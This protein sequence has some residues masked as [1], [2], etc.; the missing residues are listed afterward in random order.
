M[1]K[2]VRLL[3]IISAMFFLSKLYAQ[4]AHELLIPAPTTTVTYLSD[5]I[6]GDTTSSGTRK[7]PDRVYLLQ[8][9]GVYYNYALIRNTGWTLRIKAQ[10]GKGAKPIIYQLA[11]PTTGAVQG[12]LVDVRGDVWMQSVCVSMRLEA[13]PTTLTLNFGSVL[14]TN[15]AGFTIT[16]DSCILS[17]VSG[18]IIRTASACRAVK[19]T[20]SIL[21]NSGNLSVSNFGA[22]KGID[23]RDGSCDTLLFKNNTFVNFLDRII[24]HRTST[25]NLNNLIFDHN[26]IINSCSYHG[27]FALGWMGNSATITNNLFVDAF[28]LGADTDKVRQVEFDESGE[29][30]QYGGNAMNWVLSVPNA[31]T[32]WTVKYNYFTITPT[33][34]TWFAKYATGG[35][36]PFLP[37]TGDNLY[38]VPLTHHIKSKIGADS[39]TAFTLGTVA[40]NK[41][42]KL[43]TV[44]MDWYRSPAGGNKT[45][46]TPTS[47]YDITKQ[48]FDRKN[49]LYYRDSMDCKFS[50]SAAA[51]TAGYKGQPVGALTWWNMS[52]VGVQKVNDVIPTNFSLEQNYP[53]PFNPST[54]IA[55]NIPKQSNVKVE[56][57]DVLGR[58]VTTLVNATQA[59]GQYSVEFDA[60]RL[61]S[62]MYIYRLSTPE[63][64]I[65]RKMLLMK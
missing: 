41:Y 24:R 17:N 50:T 47:K 63:T 33:A 16:V 3:L 60:T 30:D 6:M 52:I 10:P 42:P 5:A 21:A 4:N 28:A 37:Y 27:Q 9:G 55:Y 8:R 34:Q 2:E 59:A 25:A 56:V 22:G 65:A 15:A 49:L 1:K 48:D 26:T 51:Y 62:G 32:K 40:L 35:T 54:K 11:N 38:A 20:N 14:A 43:M 31:I 53:N 44:L 18:Q 36:A 64:S 7:D 57:F 13:D 23:L 12:Q 58:L 46:N 61:S 45:K 29:K 39:T 19:V